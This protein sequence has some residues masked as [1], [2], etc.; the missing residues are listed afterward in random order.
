MSSCTSALAPTSMPRVGSSRMSTD[1]FDVEPLGQHHLLL[2]ATRE[3]AD[4]RG[5][6]RRAD[7]QALAVARRRS[8]R[9]ALAVDEPPPGDERAQARRGV[10][11]AATDCG[12][13][14]PEPAT[15]LG[16]VGDA[17]CHRLAGRPDL[18]HASPSRVIV[19]VVGRRRRR[20]APR[21]PR[22][23]PSRPAR[24]SRAPRRERT[25]KLT[26]SKAPSRPRTSTLSA[27]SPGSWATRWKKSDSSR[28]TMSRISDT[29]V[30]SATGLV[31]MCW[32]SRSTVMRSLSSNT[33][34][35]RWLTKRIAT[36]D[37]ASRRTWRNSRR[38][39]WADSAAVGSSMI[40][41]PDV[42]GHR[43][44]D[45]DRLLA[46]DGQ[47]GRRRP[48]VDVDLELAEDRRGPLVHVPPVHEPAP[49]SGP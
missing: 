6:R 4:G 47:L 1:G 14:R 29:S 32:P 35:S 27:T 36:P 41:H 40:E 31:E 49:P 11:L 9:S 33:S 16:D 19:P 5:E 23:A 7:P 12:S 37:A 22:C 21:P 48:R 26:P 20:T 30:T 8:R 43:L 13:D 42:A 25:S 28:P 34:S 24:R 17:V 44:G 2:V 39:S 18:D 10:M 38:T 15:V 3:V 45:L 46:G